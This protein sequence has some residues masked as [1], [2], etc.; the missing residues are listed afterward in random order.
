[1][2]GPGV[3]TTAIVSTRNLAISDGLVTGEGRG[4]N[5]FAPYSLSFTL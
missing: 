3:R 4:F 2:S 5:G 1:V